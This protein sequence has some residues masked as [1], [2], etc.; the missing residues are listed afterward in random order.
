MPLDGNHFTTLLT[1]NQLQPCI[2]SS[3]SE[4]AQDNA[5]AMCL[6]GIGFLHMQDVANG[7]P[8]SQWVLTLLFS[9]LSHQ[10]PH[11][12][13]KGMFHCRWT[14]LATSVEILVLE[15]SYV[16]SQILDAYPH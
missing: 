15:P 6:I 9:A 3:T 7:L 14:I 10:E 12:L 13:A 16:G 1:L 11:A 2:P 5:I 8:T 4:P